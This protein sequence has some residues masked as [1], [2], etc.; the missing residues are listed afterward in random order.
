MEEMALLKSRTAKKQPYITY[1]EYLNLAGDAQITEWV[2]GEVISY[3]S[4]F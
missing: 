3:M 1:E 2:D 4:R